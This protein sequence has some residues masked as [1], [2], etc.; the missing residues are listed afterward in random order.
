MNLLTNL[1]R[2]AKTLGVIALIG[3]ALL[4]V[5]KIYFS[6]Q[7]SWLTLGLIGVIIFLVVVIGIMLWFIIALFMQHH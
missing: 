7:L 2:H 5:S 3:L 6:L 4:A 1:L